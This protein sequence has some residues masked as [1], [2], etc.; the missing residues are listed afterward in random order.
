MIPLPPA[1]KQPA[2]WKLKLAPYRLCVVDSQI[3]ISGSKSMEGQRKAQFRT[4]IHLIVLLEEISMLCPGDAGT[5]Q[6]V[7]T[8][9]STLPMC[10]P[11]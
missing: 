1:A 4:A 6:A 3:S 10:L 7:N 11:K 9:R 8:E 2:I 5:A